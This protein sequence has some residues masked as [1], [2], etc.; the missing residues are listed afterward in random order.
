V[1]LVADLDLIEH[2][3]IDD[4][5]AVF[6]SVRTNEG[7]RRCVLDDSVDGRGHRSLHA[8]PP[9]RAPCPAVVVPVCV[10]TGAS[11]GGFSLAETLLLNVTDTLSPTLSS[12]NRF[13]PA[14]TSTVSKL[15]SAFLMFTIR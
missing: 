2:S 10:S 8:L 6:P 11:P 14:G 9:G 1:N 4:M 13:A 12:S 5:S 15:P 7:D 3:R